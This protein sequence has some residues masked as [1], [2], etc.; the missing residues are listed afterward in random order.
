MFKRFWLLVRSW[1]GA[2]LDKLE[3]PELLLTQAQQEMTE[4]HAKNR[5]RA[6]QAITQKNNLQNMVDDTQKKVDTL[7]HNAENALKRGDRDLALQILK[8]KQS[9]ESTLQSS[10]VQLETAIATAEQ[11]KE[12]IKREEL[13]IREKTAEALALKAQLK[14]NQ[15]Q[16]AMNKALEG[17]NGIENTDQAFGRATAK[18]RN[19]TS[20]MNARSELSK[21]N[22][23]GKLDQLEVAEHDSAAEAE[24]AALENK[25]G[26]SATPAPQTTVKPVEN[27]IERQL[28]ELE[29]RVGTGTGGAGA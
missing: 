25:L 27:D 29:A 7:Q 24:L 26:L 17:I 18:I 9:Y 6:V 19:S 4:M 12:A 16:I 11:V 3:D 2:G 13:K 23:Q 8:E 22:V 5:E 21:G 15:I 10:R 1:F 14:N 28:A 20:E